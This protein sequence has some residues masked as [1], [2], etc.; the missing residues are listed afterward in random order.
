MDDIIISDLIYE[1]NHSRSVSFIKSESHKEQYLEEYTGVVDLVNGEK[2]SISIA[3]SDHFPLKLPDIYINAQKNSRVHVGIDGKICLF[4]TSAILINKNLPCQII[5]DCFDQALSI[6]NLLPGTEGYNYEV[7]R[8]FVSYW[9]INSSKKLHSILNLE[10]IRYGEYPIVI[11]DNVGVV[12]STK[13]EAEVIL[14][15]SFGLINTKNTFDQKCL[16]VRIRDGSKIISLKKTFKWSTVRKYILG[17]STSSISKEFKKFL[18]FKVTSAVRFL[19]LIFPAL[20]GD[21]LFGFRLEFHNSRLSTIEK[22]INCKVENVYCERID[23]KYMTLRGGATPSL[24]NK[25]ILL[26]G[27]GS[28]GGY[29]ASN[30]CQAGITSLDIL[31]DGYFKPENVYRHLLGFDRIQPDKLGYKA[32]LVKEY[33]EKKY[34]HV[35]IDSMSFVDRSAETLLADTK[36]LNQYDLIISALGE[37]TVNLEISR[38]LVENGIKVPLICCFNEPYGIGGHVIVTNIDNSSC[39]QCLYTDLISNDIVS[40]RGSFAVSG[41]LFKRN[42]SGCSGSFVPYSCLDSQQ[43]ALYATRKAIEILTRELN[44]NILFSWLGKADDFLAQG[45]LL[46]EAYLKH[47]YNSTNQI[48][49]FTNLNC[50]ICKMRN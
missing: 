25:N 36:R 24:K 14:H 22:S 26:L 29:I 37:P 38:V 17:N 3:F 1:F 31:D 6:L 8:E 42:L 39:L 13:N 2:L 28:V 12:A 15:N 27:C 40:F 21:M 4:D 7:C 11:R 47:K 19:L 35:D 33:L 44:K 49:S 50:A 43:T 41:Q 48:D 32:D 18:K 9:L 45:Y 5:I 23:Y 46:S 10:D 34:P 16:V 20:E 30:I